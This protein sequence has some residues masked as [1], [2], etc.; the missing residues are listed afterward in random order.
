MN[1]R[2]QYSPTRIRGLA[3][4][5]MATRHKDG[6]A[7]DADRLMEE[8][9]RRL[10]CGPF[11][12]TDVETIVAWKSP[13][14][15]D[16][17][18]LNSA[19]QVETAVRQAIQATETGAVRCAVSALTKLAGVKIKMASAILTAMF[20]TLYTV[21]DFRASRALGV[22]DRS[23]LRFYVA[24]LAACR[25]MVKEYGVSLRDFDRA[26]W[27]WSKDVDKE[28]KECEGYRCENVGT[29]KGSTPT[30]SRNPHAMCSNL[31]TNH[32]TQA[33]L[34]HPEAHTMARRRD[35]PTRTETV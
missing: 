27:Q 22:K 11:N 9:G 5:Y 28:M 17:F 4:K 20:P 13:R 16:R 12:L 2:P 7:A 19:E 32:A 31:V 33:K 23:S 18:K 26:N 8:A 30:I 34:C 25:E 6:T 14:R 1:F 35:E 10:V 29:M 24:Y 15:M 21:C 3:A